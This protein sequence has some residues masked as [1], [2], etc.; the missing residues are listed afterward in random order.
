M[1]SVSEDSIEFPNGLTAAIE[2]GDFTIK[3]PAPERGIALINEPELSRLDLSMAVEAMNF[4][5]R[6]KET[7]LTGAEKGAMESARRHIRARE[8]ILFSEELGG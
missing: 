1:S 7:Y 8:L 5:L 2:D 6:Q 3:E 4:Y